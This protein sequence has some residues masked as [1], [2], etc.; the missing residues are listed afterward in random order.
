MAPCHSRLVLTS[1]NDSTINT[2]CHAKDS[3]GC[4]VNSVNIFCSTLKV[5]ACFLRLGPGLL[6]IFLGQYPPLMRAVPEFY[7][8]GQITCRYLWNRFARL[9]Q[10][11]KPGELG[12]CRPHCS[13]SSL[14]CH[15]TFTLQ[16]PEIPTLSF[17]EDSDK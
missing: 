2:T 12:V 6:V 3:R 11:I 17:Y 15:I 5:K 10:C 8:T 14:N 4:L 9:Q 1:I 7:F 16:N 13:N